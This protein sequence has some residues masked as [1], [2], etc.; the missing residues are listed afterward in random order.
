MPTFPSVRS[1]EFTQNQIVGVTMSP[2][3]GQQQVL[4]WQA[5]WAEASVELPPMESSTAQSWLAFLI[6][7]KGPVCVFQ[8]PSVLAGLL[9]SGMAPNGYWRLK[10]NASKF[11]VTLP[12]IYGLHFNIREAL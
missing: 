12:L 8:L 4:D 2:F 7:C 10:D 9:P 5:A 11:S 6:A 1:I 3:T